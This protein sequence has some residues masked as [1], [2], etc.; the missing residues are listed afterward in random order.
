MW[1]ALM[2]TTCDGAKIRKRLKRIICASLCAPVDVKDERR[3]WNTT[4]RITARTGTKSDTAR[5][6]QYYTT[7]FL[8]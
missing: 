1:I 4:A 5:I 2:T 6:T 3:I 8:K 7:M